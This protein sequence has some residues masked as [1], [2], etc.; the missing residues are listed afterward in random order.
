MNNTNE[1]FLNSKAQNDEPLHDGG[2]EVY[3]QQTQYSLLKYIL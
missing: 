2:I 1:D 3:C